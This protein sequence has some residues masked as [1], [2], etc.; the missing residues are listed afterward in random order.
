MNYN[1][2]PLMIIVRE[3][4][5]LKVWP[6]DDIRGMSKGFKELRLAHEREIVIS[7]LLF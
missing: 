4:C 3:G 7:Y 1:G 5:I 6:V 2:H